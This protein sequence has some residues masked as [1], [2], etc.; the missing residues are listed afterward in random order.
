[1]LVSSGQ[2]SAVGVPRSSKIAKMSPICG[3]CRQQPVMATAE[4]P[5]AAWHMPAEQLLMSLFAAAGPLTMMNDGVNLTK[6]VTES[7]S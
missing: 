6:L 3:E 2:I 5:T 1:M 7:K 4:V